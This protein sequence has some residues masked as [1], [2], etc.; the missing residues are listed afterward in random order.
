V[1]VVRY[2]HERWDGT[3]Y[4]DRVPGDQIPLGARIFALADALDAMTSDRPY[5]KA[6]S[7]EEATDQ[8]FAERGGQFDPQ[9]VKA[10]SVRERRLRR[11]HDELSA[12]AA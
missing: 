4:P 11:I 8:V 9:V 5:R 10:F 12:V 3:G 7:W 1:N 2:H 6:L